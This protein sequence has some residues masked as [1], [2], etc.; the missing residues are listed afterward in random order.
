MR[1]EGTGSRRTARRRICEA[2]GRVRTF[3]VMATGMHAWASTATDGEAIVWP[4]GCRDL[5]VAI[6][7]HGAPEVLCTG[8][9]R[10][11]RRVLLDAG[12]AL[13]GL[14]V[15]PGSRF[16]WDAG[17]PPVPPVER[18]LADGA[19]VPRDVLA[20]AR[21]LQRTPERAAELLDEAAA[22][23]IRPPDAHVVALLSAIAAGDRDARA[24]TDGASMRTW[25]RRMRDATGAPATFWRALH[26]VRTAARLL[27]TEGAAP[28]DVAFRAGYADQAHLTRAVRQWFATT[29]AALRRDGAALRAG[30]A[31]PD[32]FTL[33][34]SR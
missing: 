14:R 15:A 4:D 7:R 28:S 9:D 31:A 12:T 34:A 11:A 33:L 30:I 25:R 5:V 32:A 8:L 2:P 16:A 13:V 1:R 10:S 26:R 21:R 18:S 17:A 19:V 29:P 24:A 6:P 27:A 20:W 23:W 3:T 22:R